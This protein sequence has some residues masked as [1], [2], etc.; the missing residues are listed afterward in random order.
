MPLTLQGRE[1]IKDDPSAL[2][3]TTWHLTP[4]PPT[5]NVPSTPLPSTP[6]APHGDSGNLSPAWDPSSQTPQRLPDDEGQDAQY[7]PLQLIERP[8]GRA[9]RKGG[10]DVKDAAGVSDAL[11]EEIKVQVIN[12]WLNIAD[13]NVVPEICEDSGC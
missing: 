5:D 13:L 12:C 8:S 6:L 7:P 10:Y 3:L 2:S 9:N 1:F 11:H 4:V